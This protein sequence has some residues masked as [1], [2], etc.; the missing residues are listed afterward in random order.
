[1]KHNK[2]YFFFYYRHDSYDPKFESN[3]YNELDDGGDEG[4]DD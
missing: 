2:D 1:M 4:D 3:L